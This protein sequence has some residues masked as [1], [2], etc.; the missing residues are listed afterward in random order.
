VIEKL[1]D[2]YQSHYRILKL[3]LLLQNTKLGAIF[4]VGV[5]ENVPGEFPFTAFISFKREGED[6]PNVCW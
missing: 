5:A 1:K 3:K 4:Y 2:T 6:P